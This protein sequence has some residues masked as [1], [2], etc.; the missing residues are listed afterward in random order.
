M[1]TNSIE[2][3]QKEISELKKDSQK[4]ERKIKD[5]KKEDDIYKSIFETNKAIKLLIDPE[6]GKIIKANSAASNFYG[7]S[8]S[9]MKKMKIT[10]INI[11]PEKQVHID[12]K[13]AI[14]E[15]KLFFQF[16]HRLASGEIRDVEVFSGPVTIQGK[17]LLYSIIHDVTKKKKAQREMKIMASVATELVKMQSLDEIY[18]YT[19]ETIYKLLNENCIVTVVDYNFKDN[20]WHMQHISGLGKNLTEV[21]EMLGLDLNKLSGKISTQ[22][23]QKVTSGKLE[24]I[25]FDLPGLLNNRFTARMGN[26][27]RKMLSL[28]K[29][30]CI[31]FKQNDEVYGNVTIISNKSTPKIEANLIET[32]VAQVS[33]FIQKKLAED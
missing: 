3:Y 13:K 19:A 18:K 10:D 29:I 27:L 8:V 15:K 2:N 20:S 1:K 17:R 9:E 4:K 6:T 12:M 30:F 14:E 31:T 7:Y 21:S 5:L 25:E 24:E 22:Y 33:L 26:K 32:F 23:Y 28:D 16:K 11:L